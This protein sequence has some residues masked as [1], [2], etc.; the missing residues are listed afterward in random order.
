M[1]IHG[2]QGMTLDSIVI[3]A[4]K[5]FAPGQF[6]VAVSRVR[7][8]EDIYFIGFSERSVFADNSCADFEQMI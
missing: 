8:L 7:S 2:V 4:R 1:T 3:D 5:C 6:Y